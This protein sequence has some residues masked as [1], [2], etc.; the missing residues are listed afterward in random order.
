MNILKRNK[1]EAGWK[2]GDATDFLELSPKEA[3]IMEQ[4]VAKKRTRKY[5]PPSYAIDAKDKQ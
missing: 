4:Q 3:Q 2:V 1:L 5:G